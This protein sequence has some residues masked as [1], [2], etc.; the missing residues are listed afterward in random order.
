MTNCLRSSRGV[1]NAGVYDRDNM[2]EDVSNWIPE[3][4]LDK[5]VMA[6]IHP[7]M[8]ARESDVFKLIAPTYLLSV[9]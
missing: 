6:V 1:E 4:I 7:A 9:V 5:S 8:D 2:S 3:K